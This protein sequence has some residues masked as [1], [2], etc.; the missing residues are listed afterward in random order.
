MSTAPITEY[1]NKHG[2]IVYTVLICNK[3]YK[4]FLFQLP[5]KGDNTIK[6]TYL[7][8]HNVSTFRMKQK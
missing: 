7:T 1:L 6:I 5:K 8:F 4:A 3:A 2:A